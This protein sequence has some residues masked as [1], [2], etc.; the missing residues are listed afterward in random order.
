MLGTLCP[1]SMFMAVVQWPCDFERSAFY[2]KRTRRPAAPDGA[3]QGRRA[4]REGHDGQRV[5]RQGVMVS[6]C[7]VLV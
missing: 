3:V 2:A 7:P 4:L 5:V 1:S 6:G